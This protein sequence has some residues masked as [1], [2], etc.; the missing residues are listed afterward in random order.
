MGG[1]PF[2]VYLA[3]TIG[4]VALGIL[5]DSH[6]LG[7]CPRGRDQFLPDADRRRGLHHPGDPSEADPR[8]ARSARGALCAF[9]GCV[10]WGG[11]VLLVG[12]GDA[13]RCN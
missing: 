7:K 9:G 11:Y 12:G 5:S 6:P 4:L 3:L 1:V 13:E 8:S 2:R 10:F